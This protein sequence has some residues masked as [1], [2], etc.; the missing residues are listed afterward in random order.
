MF[1]GFLGKGK[2]KGEAPAK[3][4]VDSRGLEVVEDD[5]DTTWGLWQDAVAEQDSRL[6]T[7]D[8][9]EPRPDAAGAFLHTVPLPIMEDAS[10][11]VDM[12]SEELTPGQRR[13]LAL[14]VVELHH[15]RIAKSIRALWGYKECSEY[16]SKMIMDGGYRE[17]HQRM[18]FNQDAA[19]AMMIL[20]DVHDKEYGTHKG[21]KALGYGDPTVRTGL[22]G[23]R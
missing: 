18:G 4:A 8:V 7:L 11:A 2:K 10:A 21:G 17:G 5:P 3:D 15:S 14:Q 20:S 23:T 19:Q 12:N 16:I 1:G 6:S 22:D 13:E 9:P